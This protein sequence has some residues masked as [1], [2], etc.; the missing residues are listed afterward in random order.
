[1][2]QSNASAV[3]FVDDFV[4]TG[5]QFRDTWIRRHEIGPADLSFSDIAATATTQF[6]YCPLFCTSFALEH[7]LRDIKQQVL[8]VPS[9]IIPPSYSVFAPDSFVWPSRLR[10][11]ATRFLETASARA[12][13]PDTNGQDT[14]DWRGFAELGLTIAFNHMVPDATIPLLYTDRN[15]WK[16]LF[17]RP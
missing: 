12:G 4:G 13:L 16:P 10:P 5:N 8:I 7:A 14:M 11:S 2:S 3:V 15:D 6:F 1:M 9:H 17:R